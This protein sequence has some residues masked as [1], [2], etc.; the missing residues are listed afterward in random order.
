M[1]RMTGPDRAVMC[2]LINTHTHT[3]T[4]TIEYNAST[5]VSHQIQPEYGEQAGWRGM[6]RPNPSC[7]TRFSGTN[8]D[9]ELS[10]FPFQLTTSRISNLTRVDPY[11]VICDDHAH[12]LHT[13]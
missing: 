8:G 3:H 11:S 10:I 9:W 1:T 5:V 12:I 4:E 2:N 6:G 13:Y 7:E